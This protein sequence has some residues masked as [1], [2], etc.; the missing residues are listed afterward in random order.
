MRSDGSDGQ[1]RD[2]IGPEEEKR[3]Y[4][5]E[6]RRMFEEKLNAMSRAEYAVFIRD[7]VVDRVR[8]TLIV[9][10]VNALLE[11]KKRLDVLLTALKYEDFWEYRESMAGISEKYRGL[12]AEHVYQLAKKDCMEKGN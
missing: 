11:E 4:T 2:S 5:D 3:T 6:E 1:D 7:L 9:P 8:E 10:M 12:D